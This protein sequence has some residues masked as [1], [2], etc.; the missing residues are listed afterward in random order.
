ME[1]M[2]NYIGDVTEDNSLQDQV[3]VIVEEQDAME[4][5][6]ESLQDLITGGLDGLPDVA[7][8]GS[9]NDLSDKPTIPE[10]MSQLVNDVGYITAQQVQDGYLTEEDLPTK[11]SEFENDRGFVTNNAIGRGVL[12]VNINGNKVGEWMANEK[13]NITLD[14]PVDAQLSATSNLPVENR[15]ITQMIN[16]KDGEVLNRR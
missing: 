9:Y 15:V 10:N 7:L 11:L 1:T 2:F 5:K 6:V 14:I 12:T 8:S 13:D 3:N 4:R 16:Q